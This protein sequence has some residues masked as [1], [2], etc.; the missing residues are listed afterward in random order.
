MPPQLLHP[1]SNTG[2]TVTKIEVTFQ[3]GFWYFNTQSNS[4]NIVLQMKILSA[5]ASLCNYLLFLSETQIKILF[6]DMI[7]KKIMH[8]MIPAICMYIFTTY[9]F[10]N[11]YTALNLK[12]LISYVFNYTVLLSSQKN[13]C[14]CSTFMIDVIL[15]ILYKYIST[16]ILYVNSVL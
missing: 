11:C 6:L 15:Y 16:E 10:R 2:F 3:T 1:Y 7:S 13:L 9:T 8:S 14:I 4:Y 12:I 5:V